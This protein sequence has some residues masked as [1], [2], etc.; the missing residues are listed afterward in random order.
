MAAGADVGPREQFPHA[1][2]VTRALG[3][4]GDVLPSLRRE[5]LCVGDSFL[6]CS[7]GLTEAVAPDRIAALLARP[8][9]AACRALVEAAYASG[10]RDNITAVVVR[11][12]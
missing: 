11:A 4:E 3:M 8:A 9:E 5:L 2:V 6:L 7:D 10:G 12:W 1:N